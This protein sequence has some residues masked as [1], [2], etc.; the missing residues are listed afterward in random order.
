MAVVV[1]YL[2]GKVVGV[3]GTRLTEASGYGFDHHI[4]AFKLIRNGMRESGFASRDFY[5]LA[6]ARL[7]VGEVAVIF[8]HKGF[9]GEEQL[10]I[11]W[12]IVEGQLGEV[13]VLQSDL[14][15]FHFKFETRLSGGEL[16]K[17]LVA[18]FLI[19][20]FF[21]LLIAIDFIE[22]VEGVDEEVLPFIDGVV[23]VLFSN[24][25]GG[26]GVAFK[27]G[28]VKLQVVVLNLLFQG[29]WVDFGEVL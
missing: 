10:D 6:K 16:V 8:F 17:L 19:C 20:S 12:I 22:L 2:N 27:E 11:H 15:S 4:A 25:S 24:D 26:C 23:F 1:N 18:I 28:N 13:L 7:D 29:L 5:G 21:G 3:V 14:V 9:A